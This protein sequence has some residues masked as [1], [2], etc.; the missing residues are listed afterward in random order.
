MM[1]TQHHLLLLSC[2]IILC[3][4]ILFGFLDHQSI[5]ARIVKLDS[6]GHIIGFFFLTLLLHKFT[7]LH[8]FSLVIT[9]ILY[10]ALTEVG[11]Y[12]LGFRNGELS[13]FFAD[14]TGIGCF[15]LLKW[16]LLIRKSWNEA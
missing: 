3:S 6:V 2:L 10:A 4:A 5:F 14:I 9:L 12:Y 8:S 11:Q 13:D 16:C 15:L 1:K 7:K